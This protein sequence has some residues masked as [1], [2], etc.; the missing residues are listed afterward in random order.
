MIPF[1]D[2]EPLRQRPRATF[3]AALQSLQM[4][5]EDRPETVGFPLQF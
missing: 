3:D 4:Q 5:A 2:I 1:A